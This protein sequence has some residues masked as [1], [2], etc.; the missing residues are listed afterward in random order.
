[1]TFKK[2]LTDDFACKRVKLRCGRRFDWLCV[3]VESFAGAATA[4]SKQRKGV[5][6]VFNVLSMVR[7]WIICDANT[8]LYRLLYSFKREANA[9][10][11]IRTTLRSNES[12]Q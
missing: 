1:M 8:W 10:A 2:R 11:T 12:L 6:H 3:D 4:R 9:I 7:R 5:I